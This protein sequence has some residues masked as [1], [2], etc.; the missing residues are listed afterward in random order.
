VNQVE[1]VYDTLVEGGSAPGLVSEVLLH[2]DDCSTLLIAA[3]AY[4]RD[5]WRLYDE[6]V[7]ALSGLT[8]ADALTWLPSRQPWRSTEGAPP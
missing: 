7:V 4:D 2:G 1:V 6:S 5:E 3:E 8:D